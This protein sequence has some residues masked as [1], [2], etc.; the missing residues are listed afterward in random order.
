MSTVK[1]HEGHHVGYD[2]EAT[3]LDPLDDRIITAAIV[4]MAPGKRP[5]P[6]EWLI[7][8]QRDIPPD[9]AAV[10]G[11]TL[12]RLEARLKGAEALR[13][14]RGR[15]QRLPRDGALFEI[16]SQAATAMGV[17]APL[18]VANAPYDLTMLETELTREGIDT[19][20]SRPSGVRGVVDPLVIEKA[21][22]G[23]RAVCQAADG[24]RPAERHH[25]CEGCQG[26]KHQ[27]GGCGV[28]DKKLGS[29]CRHYGVVHVGAHDASAD[30]VAAVR[31]AR[32]LAALW[33]LIARWKLATL[34]SHQVTWRADQQQARSARDHVPCDP[35]WPV[36]HR[37]AASERGAA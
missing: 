29:L 34:H 28:T 8:P 19:L 13:I 16:A 20:A 31:L 18:V 3:G 4:H 2:S 26:G 23:S 27:C 22:D 36:Q 5:A 33:P 15:A 1:W 32:K 37:A 17:E 30:A 14:H 7:H 25:E 21:Y 35:T 9:A 10:H 24:C 6:I 12:D 11:W